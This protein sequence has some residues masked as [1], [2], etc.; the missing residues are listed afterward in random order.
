ML[1]YVFLIIFALLNQKKMKSFDNITFVRWGSLNKAKHKE[2]RKQQEENLYVFEPGYHVAPTYKGIYAFPQGLVD[3]FLLGG[4]RPSKDCQRVF[5]L[6]D[7]NGNKLHYDDVVQWI[8]GEYGQTTNQRAIDYCIIKPKYKALCHKYGIKKARNIFSDENGY[9]CYFV[10]KHHHF[11]YK[12]DL[13]HHLDNDLKPQDIID[14]KGCWV[15]TSYQVYVQQLKRYIYT[16]KFDTYLEF[17]KS[18]DISGN[19]HGM[20]NFY[21]K[22]HFEVF[23]NNKI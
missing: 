19:P 7:E 10:H 14:K 8:F 5:F 17:K 4:V 16:E 6:K 21:S 11:T 2:S 22:E 18:K 9:A 15:K 12:G 23:I 1:P 13:W 3:D 20:R